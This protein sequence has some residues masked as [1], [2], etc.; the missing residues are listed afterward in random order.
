MSA[1]EQDVNELFTL[2]DETA[3]HSFMLRMSV[4][5]S[6]LEL[7]PKCGRAQA[8]LAGMETSFDL[9]DE[10]TVAIDKVEQLVKRD[11]WIEAE[12]AINLLQKLYGEHPVARAWLAGARMLWKA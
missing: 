4:L 5:K 6:I 11:L 10:V 7:D 2:I 3:P 12:Y 1:V 8:L 9:Q